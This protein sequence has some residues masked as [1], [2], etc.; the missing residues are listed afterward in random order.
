[1][2]TASR[3]FR[4]MAVA[5][6]LG[7]AI[8]SASA[9][10]YKG[11]ITLV[12]GYPAGGSADIGARILAEKLPALLGQPVIVENRAG[13]GG[14]IAARYVKA[15]SP[16]GSVLFFTNGHTVVTVPLVLKAPGF[17]TRTDLQPVSPFATFELVLAAHAT[18]GAH[19]VKQLAAYFAGNP[20]DRNIAVPAPGSA[21]EFMVGRLAQLTRSDIQPIAYKGS[22][23]AVQD[24]LGGQV[25]AAIV[26][27]GDA[28]QYRASLRLLAVT[29]KTPL[30]PD[31]PSFADAGLPELS[32]SDFLA[33]YAPR[34]MSADEVTRINTAVQKVIAMPDVS[35][36]LL[37]YAM[38]PQSGAPADLERIFTASQG[39]VRNLMAAVNYQPQ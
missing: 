6:L 33:V 30:L 15:A 5:C 23:P 2:V 10:G 3:I 36:R 38:Q 31:V 28:L 21:P 13:A 39:T 18:T 27:L 19:D 34:G 4:H 29:R 17:D 12:V 32:A 25:A 35:R 9:E 1:M 20:K 22:G 11:P 14:Q 7:L 16:N 8:T 26:P 37:S 24:L